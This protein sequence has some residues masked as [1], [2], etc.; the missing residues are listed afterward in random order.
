M[1]SSK[2]SGGRPTVAPPVCSAARA[3]TKALGEAAPAAR[4]RRGCVRRHDRHA[5]QADVLIAG[6]ALKAYQCLRRCRG[7]F[8][9][10]LSPHIA[11]LLGVIVEILRGRPG[12]GGDADRPAIYWRVIVDAQMKRE[13]IGRADRRADGLLDPEIGLGV[14]IAGQVEEIGSIGRGAAETVAVRQPGQ[15]IARYPAEH[16]PAGDRLAATGERLAVACR[17]AEPFR[18]LFETAV[19]DEVHV[20]HSRQAASGDRPQ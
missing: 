7:E 8:Q 12:R 4:S 19:P 6:Q 18:R 13:V 20:S 15:T 2:A 9:R 3:L 5:V 17:R 11:G 1:R 14:V 10:E 16:R